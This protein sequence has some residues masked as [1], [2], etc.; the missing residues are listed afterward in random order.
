MYC[1]KCGRVFREPYCEK[2]KI[3]IPEENKT[4]PYKNRP[5][6]IINLIAFIFFP[7]FLFIELFINPKTPKD[8]SGIRTA[9]KAFWYLL[10]MFLM[11]I[12]AYYGMAYISDV[13]IICRYIGRIMAWGIIIFMIIV[14]LAEKNGAEKVYDEN[15]LEVSG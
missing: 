8:R 3:A 9:Q 13:F 15:G 12:I 11:N 7:I 6:V 4:I 10:V 1:S 5:S 14:I 2:C